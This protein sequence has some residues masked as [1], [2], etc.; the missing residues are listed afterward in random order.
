MNGSPAGSRLDHRHWQIAAWTNPASHDV[1]I[2]KTGSKL[3]SWTFHRSQK[4]VGCDLV[5]QFMDTYGYS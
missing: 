5:I 2:L 3:E 4:R 1:T